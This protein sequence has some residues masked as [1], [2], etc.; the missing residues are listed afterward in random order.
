MP[1]ALSAKKIETIRHL[2]A[3]GRSLSSI[4]REL[5]VSPSTVHKYARPGSFE[6]TQTAAAVQAHQLDAAARRAAISERLLTIVD[7]LADRMGSEY[8]SFG[9]FGKDGEY[10]HRTHPLPPAGEMRQFSGALSSLMATH[11]RLVAQD[12]DG[13]LSDAVSV[14]DGFMDAVAERAAEIRDTT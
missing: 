2:A 5:H 6:R 3:D 12:S 8:L 13:G 4:A 10:R 11:L 1:S 14:L 7:Q 9:W